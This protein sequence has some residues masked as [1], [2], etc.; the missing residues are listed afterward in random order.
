MKKRV[1]LFVTLI[2]LAVT[3]KALSVIFPLVIQR[4]IDAGVHNEMSQVS[5]LIILLCLI[6]ILNGIVDMTDQVLGKKYLNAVSHSYRERIT[7]YIL[8]LEPDEFCKKEKSEYFSIINNNIDLVVNNFYFF[9]LN[10]IKC[11]LVIVFT[12]SALFSLNSILTIIIVITAAGT[13]ISPFLFRK[14]LDDQNNKIS[15]SLKN[16]NSKL[17]DFLEGYLTGRI[18]LV[19]QKF[20]SRVVDASEDVSK[21]NLKYWKYM[22]EPNAVSVLL[23]YGRDIS[24][25]GIGIYLMSKGSL[26]VGALFAAIQLSNLLSAPAVNLSYLIS[27]IVSSKGIKKELDQMYYEGK[28]N[29]SVDKALRRE[30]ERPMDLKIQNLMFSYEDKLVLN[31][32][33]LHIEAGKKY[34][35]VG[36]S[37]SGKSS[38]MRILAK[39]STNYKGNILAD[40][41]DLCDI[42]KSEWYSHISVSLQDSVMFHDTLYNNLTLWDEL[43]NE[44]LEGLVDQLNLRTL[45]QENGI[46][47]DCTNGGSNFSGGEQQRIA[48]IRSLLESKAL[49][50]IDEATSALDHVNYQVVESILLG[51]KSTVVNI[52]HKIHP[53]IAKQYD[54]IL[55]LKDG[56]L[57]AEGTYEELILQEKDFQEFLQI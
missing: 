13:V 20:R 31:D 18:F 21:E 46:D 10:V 41:R 48:L 53:E 34:L 40:S 7:N 36:A 47:C 25:V 57:A 9:I 8:H 2:I 55:F 33:N 38:L 56:K 26:T 44:K 30:S 12:I 14:R 35:L 50:L 52:T 4:A 39:F 42:S 43:S 24:L 54:A 49:L 27:S 3:T 19:G 1:L 22:Q 28:E 11:I 17:D 6:G 51:T 45:I 16:L 37:G 32:I 29:T 5:S 23:T 15:S